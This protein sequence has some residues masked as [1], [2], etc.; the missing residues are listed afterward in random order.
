MAIEAASITRSHKEITF[1]SS[2]PIGFH[3]KSL[4]VGQSQRR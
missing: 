1:D 3:I 4:S 2:D